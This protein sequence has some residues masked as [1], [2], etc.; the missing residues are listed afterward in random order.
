MKATPAAGYSLPAGAQDTWN[1]KFSTGA[2]PL[3]TVVAPTPTASDQPGT[4]QDTVTVTKTAGITWTVNGAPVTFSGTNTTA[5]VYVTTGKDATVVA[6]SDAGYAFAGNLA[7]QSFTVKL[8]DVKAEPASTR[9]SGASRM[10]TAVEVSK[11]YWTTATTVYVANGW[12]YADALAAG[13]AAAKDDAPL[14]LVQEDG[15]PTSVLDEI[16]RLKPARIHIVGGT[17]VVSSGVEATLNAVAPVTRL[18][19]GTRY[20]TAAAVAGKWADGS[21]PVVYLA[22][23]E[24][25]PD[26]LS[27]GSGAA[28]EDGALLLSTKTTMTQPTMDALKRLKP[29]KVVLVGG[30]D[31]LADAVRLEVKDAVGVDAARYAGADRYA[32]SAAVALGAGTAV[33]AD[34]VMFLATG[35]NFPDALAGVPAADK[36][37]APLFLSQPSCMP[38]SVKSVVDKNLTGLTSTVRLGSEGVLGNFPLTAVC[39]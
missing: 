35:L 36:I 1:F 32:T 29:K 33:P 23:G 11:K 30:T 14:L 7:A 4:A 38:A 17:S 6:T 8:T 37:G 20:A 18:A 31:V 34:K 28:G 16:K 22:L 13:P 25:F 12:R 2:S 27:G 39:A 5:S 24:N 21:A 9:L 10:D 3:T 15:V 26:A 19:G